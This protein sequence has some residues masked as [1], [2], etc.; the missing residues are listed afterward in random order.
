MNKTHS[1][2]YST[3]Q[4]LSEA[5]LRDLLAG[6]GGRDGSFAVPDPSSPAP[7]LSVRAVYTAHHPVDSHLRME[8]HGSTLAHRFLMCS[9][10]S[11]E[12][13]YQARHNDAQGAHLW[14]AHQK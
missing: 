2:L 8:R 14:V 6:G 7:T 9:Q 12:F 5:F 3:L 13:A 1:V 10:V 4:L 11:S